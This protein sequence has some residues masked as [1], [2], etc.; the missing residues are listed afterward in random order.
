MPTLGAFRTLFPRGVHDNT[1]KVNVW[2]Q[3]T[4]KRFHEAMED[5][6]QQGAVSALVTVHFWSPGLLN[7][8]EV[9]GGFPTGIDPVDLAFL[10][11]LEDTDGAVLAI[12]PLDEILR[13]PLPDH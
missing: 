2:L 9:A 6:V 3:A 11:R 13:G 5:S 12:V 7:V 8:R 10:S 1:A 4:P